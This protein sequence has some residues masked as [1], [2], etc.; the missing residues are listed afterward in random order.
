MAAENEKPT[1]ADFTRWL[2]RTDQISV[3]APADGS[4]R[5][6]QVLASARTARD[7]SLRLGQQLIPAVAS[8]TLEVLQLLAAADKSEN[9]RPPE[10]TTPKGF[11]VTLAYDDGG[12]AVGPSIAVLV[13]CPAERIAELQG[14]TVFLWNSAERF[15][16]GQFDSD[17][18]ALGTLPAGLEITL[19]D[20]K[21]GRVKLEEPNPPTD[22]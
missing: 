1:F 21:M 3:Q 11:R 7:E 6:Q 12:T 14:Q 22:G 8:G 18:K 20:F 19:S 13:Q 5:H 4:A 9:A 15:E 10:L 17:G 2:A 16:L